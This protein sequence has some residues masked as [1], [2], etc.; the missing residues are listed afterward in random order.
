MIFV[1]DEL[2]KEAKNTKYRVY[3]KSPLHEGVEC[4]PCA[5][6]FEGKDTYFIT[7]VKTE[8]IR[9]DKSSGACKFYYTNE[10]LSEV[11]DW[12]PAHVIP[13][14]TKF[15]KIKKNKKP[16]IGS[17]NC[18]VDVSQLPAFNT[19]TTNEDVAVNEY[20]FFLT[21][22]NE[23]TISQCIYERNK[24]YDAKV[25]SSKYDLPAKLQNSDFLKSKDFTVINVRRNEMETV[26]VGLIV[27]ESTD[28]YVIEY[29]TVFIDMN[30]IISIKWN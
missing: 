18:L 19:D 21:L 12:F 26:P 27:K 24:L 5:T 9:C 23:Y 6:Q 16:C 28:K 15:V 30:N 11:A 29:G 13:I 14:G 1:K 10:D 20:K 3:S 17:Y 2:I 25:T 8:N 7:S 22:F 4:F